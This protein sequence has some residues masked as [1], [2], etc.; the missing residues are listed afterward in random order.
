MSCVNTGTHEEYPNQTRIIIGGNQICYPVDVGT[1]T[2]SLEL[3]KVVINSVLSSHNARFADCDVGNFYLATPMDR[4]ESVRI[5]LDYIPK[6]F[7]AEYNLIPYA[8]NGW[9]YL[10]IIKGCYSL[11]QS[12]MLAND[13][14]RTRLNN[15][16]Y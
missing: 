8:N 15:D 13:L 14:L 3:V 4:P 1:P 11:P 7:I 10:K 2:G 9:I 5:R 16:G 12:G 6:E